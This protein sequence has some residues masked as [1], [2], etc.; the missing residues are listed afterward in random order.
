MDLPT[1]PLPDTTPNT[2]PMWLSGCGAL[3]KDCGVARSAQL[4]PQV[5]QLWVHSLIDQYS[6]LLRGVPPVDQR[7]A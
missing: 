7:R 5:E 4:S 1:P 2:L 3:R 6:P